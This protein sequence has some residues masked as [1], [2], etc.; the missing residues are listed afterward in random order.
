MRSGRVSRLLHSSDPPRNADVTAGRRFLTRF[1]LP[2]MR[3]RLA[4]E[5]PWRRGGRPTQT[6][7]VPHRSAY[8]CLSLAGSLSSTPSTARTSARGA[9]GR[10][11]SPGTPSRRRR[12]GTGTPGGSSPYCSTPGSTSVSAAADADPGTGR[13]RC[14]RCARAWRTRGAAGCRSRG[15]SPR[16]RRSPGGRGCGGRGYGGRGY[17]GQDCGC[18]QAVPITTVAYSSSEVTARAARPAEVRAEAVDGDWRALVSI[19]R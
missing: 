6:G 11:S 3:P 9:A 14:G 19:S 10:C 16:R 2:P 18:A 7:R 17:G 15:H 12:A 1:F 5:I 4:A 13:G 8:V